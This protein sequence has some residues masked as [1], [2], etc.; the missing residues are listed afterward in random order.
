MYLQLINISVNNYQLNIQI[1]FN[2]RS[3]NRLLKNFH[4][5]ITVV[6]LNHRKMDCQYK[7]SFPA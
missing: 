2:I 7:L 1:K 5:L 4:N 6:L 3:R